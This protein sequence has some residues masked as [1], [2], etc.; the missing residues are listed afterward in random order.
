MILLCLSSNSF[1]KTREQTRCFVSK[2]TPGAS[3]FWTFMETNVF[4]NEEIFGTEIVSDDVVLNYDDFRNC[5]VEM[6]RAPM[7]T[8]CTS[9]QEDFEFWQ[10]YESDNKKYD[11]GWIQLRIGH[12]PHDLK[13]G[14]FEGHWMTSDWKRL[15]KTAW[16]DQKSKE[17]I[18]ERTKNIRG[19]DLH[20]IFALGEEF[21]EMDKTIAVEKAHGYLLNQKKDP[22]SCDLSSV[23]AIQHGNKYEDEAG[24]IHTW[25]WKDLT[26]K[27]GSI[28]HKNP[29]YKLAISPDLISWRYKTAV[30][31]K[32]PAYRDILHSTTLEK[33][34]ELEV[35][36]KEVLLFGKD[37]KSFTS[38]TNLP[39]DCVGFVDKLHA[40]WH[41]CQMQMEVIGFETDWMFFTQYGI[42][43]NPYYK[44][45]NPMISFTKVKRS[46]TWFQES[47]PYFEKFWNKLGS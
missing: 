35:L 16:M 37:P 11:D 22:S 34:K 4:R 21:K 17:W 36:E 44:N 40:Y 31:L 30:E 23:P 29:N 7:D 32:A 38:I 24:Y 6:S 27:F 42:D 14:L 13:R 19:S 25:F 33:S 12:D 28:P 43:P 39:E 26:F 1:K 5:W 10:K 45:Q 8:S 2:K 46:S 3:S 9:E 15:F 18:N 47:L 41:Q 20:L